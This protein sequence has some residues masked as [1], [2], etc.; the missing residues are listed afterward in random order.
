LEIAKADSKL[1]FKLFNSC[2]QAWLCHCF[3]SSYL[4]VFWYPKYDA[5]YG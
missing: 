5:Y 1:D 3:T 4:S 2:S